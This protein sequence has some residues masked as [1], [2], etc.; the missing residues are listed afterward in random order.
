MT[1]GF[2]WYLNSQI[3]IWT[4]QTQCFGVTPSAL[5]RSP[6]TSVVVSKNNLQRGLGVV[7][8][9]SLFSPFPRVDLLHP[10]AQPFQTSNT[11]MSGQSRRI[12]SFF[13]GLN[14]IILALAVEL[15]VR[16]RPFSKPNPNLSPELGQAYKTQSTQVKGQA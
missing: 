6:C 7:A 11:R 14:N 1:R 16:P 2:S 10:G 4:L 15:Y 13:G 5:V 9:L 8:P 12:I 3:S